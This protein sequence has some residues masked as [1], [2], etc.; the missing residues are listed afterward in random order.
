MEKFIGLLNQVNGFRQMLKGDGDT[1][2]LVSLGLD[3]GLGPLS[4]L[5][6]NSSGREM[7]ILY[8]PSSLL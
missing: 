1:V 2:M 4:K 8:N 7:E 6:G 5:F 3:A